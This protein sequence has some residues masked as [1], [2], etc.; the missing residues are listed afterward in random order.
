MSQ[1][2]QRV[3]KNPYELYHSLVNVRTTAQRN[4][5]ELRL[6]LEKA[7]LTLQAR[8]YAKKEERSR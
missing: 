4:P 3:R 6:S 2:R 8:S 7:R 5:S 1:A